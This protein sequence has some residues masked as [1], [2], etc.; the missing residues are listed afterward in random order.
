MKS[1]THPKRIPFPHFYKKILSTPLIWLIENLNLS[2]SKGYSHYETPT[3][4]T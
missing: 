4:Q 2:I 1:S 3:S